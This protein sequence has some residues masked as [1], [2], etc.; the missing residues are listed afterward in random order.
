MLRIG[1]T[2]GIGSGKTLVCRIFEQLGVPVYYA[3][4]AA[5]EIFYRKDIQQQIIKVFGGKLIDDK[6]F[7][8]RKQ[9][10]ALVFNDKSL[11][12][13]LNAIIHPAVA[14][15]VEDWSRKNA[16]AK[17][18]LKEAAILFESGTNKGLDKVITVTA[19]VDLKIARVI[20][21][22]VWSREE[23]EK[24]MQNQWSDEEKIKRSDFVIYNDEQHLVI[25]QVL[26]IHEKIHALK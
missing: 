10:S 6:G 24:R 13:K 12:E 7:I 9:L 16:H 14:L 21:R 2:G 8:D 18:V 23:V 19:P 3:D 5:T 17:Y 4:T 20:K 25:P 26:A 1:I 15:D 22:E 11:L